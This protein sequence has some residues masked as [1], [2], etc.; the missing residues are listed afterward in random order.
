MLHGS[1]GVVISPSHSRVCGAVRAAKVPVSN[2]C[3]P[4]QLRLKTPQVSVTLVDLPILQGLKF[5][6]PYSRIIEFD[7]PYRPA[8]LS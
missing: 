1:S 2:A 5:D 7:L 8:V 4:Y 3:Q 6:I